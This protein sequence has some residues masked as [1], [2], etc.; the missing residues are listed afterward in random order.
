MSSLL[1]DFF[2]KSLGMVKSWQW[3]FLVKHSTLWNITSFYMSEPAFLEYVENYN[4]THSH[5]PIV[6]FKKVKASERLNASID[7][8]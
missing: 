4:K 1:T 3:I 6:D 2:G 7:V 8:L 5:F